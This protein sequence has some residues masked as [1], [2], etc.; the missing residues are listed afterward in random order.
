MIMAYTIVDQHDHGKYC[1]Q[2]SQFLFVTPLAYPLIVL[3]PVSEMASQFITTWNNM[4][5]TQISMVKDFSILN[6]LQPTGL[7][8]FS[9]PQVT[10]S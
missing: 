7:Y 6:T 10:C 5:P 8:F 2:R 9:C 4:T 3:A 1:S